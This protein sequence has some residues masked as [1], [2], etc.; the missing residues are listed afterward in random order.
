MT[1]DCKDDAQEVAAVWEAVLWGL[2]GGS[3]LVVGA[4]LALVGRWPPKAI[5]WAR[6]AKARR[7]KAPLRS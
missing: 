3:T 4:G 6:A 5:R 2:V 7:R 1:R